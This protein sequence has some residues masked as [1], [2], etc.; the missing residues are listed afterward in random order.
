LHVLVL[1]GEELGDGDNV[2]D[3]EEEERGAGARQT[4]SG[5]LVGMRNWA[6][7]QPG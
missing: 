1:R 5:K 2:V 7:I 3:A 6:V 4:A